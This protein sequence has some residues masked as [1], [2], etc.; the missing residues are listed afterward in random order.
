VVSDQI[1]SNNQTIDES[2]ILEAGSARINTGQPA[3]DIHNGLNFVADGIN[4]FDVLHDL[5]ISLS[6]GLDK[7]LE[8]VK[9]SVSG[10][11]DVNVGSDVAGGGN[12]ISPLHQT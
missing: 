10:K 8:G 3:N 4:Q 12:Q 7:S 1:V 11:N 5:P 2:N 9:V 6:C